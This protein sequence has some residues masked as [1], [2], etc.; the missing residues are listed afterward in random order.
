[1]K[2]DNSSEKISALITTTLSSFLLPFMISSVNIALPSIA[3]DFDMGAVS[4]GWVATAYIL[5]AAIFLV[6]FGK[7]ADI[8]GRKR[9]FISGMFIYSIASL[10]LAFSNSSAMLITL[11]VLQG[12]GASMNFGTSTA[13]LS[14]VYPPNERG[15]VFGINVA[16]VYLGLSLGPTVG[17]ILTQALTWRSIFALSV[18]LGLAVAIVA[19]TKLKGEWA[20]AKGEKFDLAGSVIY[21]MMLVALMHGFSEITKLQGIL[22]TAIGVVLFFVFVLWETKAKYP[23]LEV[24]L[25]KSNR[26][27]AF[28]NLAAL[29]NYSATWAVTFLL[30]LYL[31]YIK[32]LSPRDAG[33]VLLAQPIVQAIL[34]PISGRISDRIEPRIVASMGM[35]ATVLGLILLS[36]INTNTPIIYFIIT[37]IV[38]GFG[39]ALFSAPNTNAIMSSVEK[40]YY[41]VASGIL[42]TM[43]MIGQMMSMG[44][45]MLIFTIYIGSAKITPE[46]YDQFLMSAKTAFRIFSIICIIG[47]L[48]SLNRGKVRREN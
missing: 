18:P 11:R 26:A 8:Y 6:P 3:I 29:I 4:M 19:I 24:R 15:K 22:Q 23:V 44:I 5:S 36:F 1:M 32:A 21:A 47:V 7:I 27:F 12:I 25:F 43:R 14:S 16:A 2:Q 20:E 41:G 37:L 48:A 35:G 31:Q 13:I 34:S 40:R 39:F 42:G 45:V 10:L 9:I 30:S 28:S 46:N 17:G 38:S 33:L